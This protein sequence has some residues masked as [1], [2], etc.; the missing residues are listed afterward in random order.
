MAFENILAVVDSY[1]EGL[2][3]VMSRR[4][5]WLEKHKEVRDHLKEIATFLAEKSAYKPGFFVDVNHA[6]NEPS[7]GTCASLPS[8][9]L[10]SG[11]MSLDVTFKNA[12]GEKKEYMEE[13][14]HLT[15]TPT[16]TGQILILLLPHYSI[17]FTERPEYMTL[18]VIDDPAM[19]TPDAV[20]QIVEKA[21][22]TAFYSSFTG[23]AE[24][25]HREADGG[26]K[27]YQHAPIGFKRY[28]STE[29]VK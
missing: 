29:K 22:N 4:G 27:Q 5:H 26:Q 13:G 7:N 19:L 11:P 14:F 3:K 21:I 23:M 12:S 28:E 15:L 18:A 2:K 16:I 9:T 24:L 17:L 25:R 10:R 6:Y 20:D 8:L 1:A